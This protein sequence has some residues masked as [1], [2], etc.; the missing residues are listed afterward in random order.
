MFVRCFLKGFRFLCFSICGRVTSGH[1]VVF[2][3]R[4]SIDK[5][6]MIFPYFMLSFFPYCMLKALQNPL[7]QTTDN[8]NQ[9]NKT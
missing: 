3:V 2:P 8:H 7:S 1:F 9:K 4:I 6:V 5:F